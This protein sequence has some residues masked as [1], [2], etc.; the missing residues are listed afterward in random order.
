MILQELNRYYERLQGDPDSKVPPAHWSDEKV[1]WELVIAGDGHLV[2]VHPLGAGGK[3]SARHAL[4]LRVPEHED[5]SGT[6]IKPFFLCDTI[7]FLLG[8][9]DKR[10]PEK[11][12]EARELHQDILSGCDDSGAK[13]VL[14]F[15][16]RN[17]VLTSLSEDKKE[18]LAAHGGSAVFRLQGDSCRLHDKEALVEAWHAHCLAS[19]GDVVV[20]Q[21]GI[22]GKRVPLARLFRQVKGVPGAQS[23]GA[24]LVS[25]NFVSSESYGKKQSYNAAVSEEVALNAS[26]AL[27]YLY[28]DPG[29]RVRFGQTTVLF[30]TDRPASLEEEAIRLMMGDEPDLRA[31]NKEDVQRIQVMLDHIKSGKPLEG[32]NPET[33]FFILGI[34]PN[35]ARLAV[36]FFEVGTFGKLMEHYGEY[37]RDIDMVGVRPRSLRTLLRQTAPLGEADN[38]P[39]TLVHGCMHAMLTG[40]RFPQALFQL[41]LT[42]M[43]ADRGSNNAWDMGQ[44]AAL[45]KAC[46][47]RKERLEG[48]GISNEGKNER[49]LRVELNNDNRDEGYVLGRLFAVMERAQTAAVGDVS[50]TIKDRFIAAAATSPARVFPSL[51]R[52]HQH[53]M[54]KLRKTNAGLCIK[55]EKEMDAI[56][57]L[58]GE[59]P[60]FPT[61]LDMV[62]Q[63]NFYVGYY[64]ER[65]HLWRGKSSEEVLPE[66][67]ASDNVSADNDGE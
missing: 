48:R 50:A 38:V 58:L 6:A 28:S 12:M 54:A 2:D 52:S 19:S 23:A 47:V 35:A 59:T 62:Q 33:R 42:R 22:T 55:F 4:V 57:K 43:R 9:G 60:F 63:G 31:E 66:E 53:H 44:R 17:D 46:I 49:S 45:L 41:L 67:I 65:E 3:K 24:S 21:C 27:R 15:F 18:D 5:R 64:Q 7:A 51:L 8:L 36:R 25:F 26:A 10:G 56:M 20:G 11:R 32:C 34:A 37:L 61:S 40:G 1:S 13:A 39:A 14:A 16:N 29:H 30:W